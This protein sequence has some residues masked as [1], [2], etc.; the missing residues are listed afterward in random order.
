MIAVELPIDL[1]CCHITNKSKNYKIIFLNHVLGL[2]ISK[3]SFDLIMTSFMGLFAYVFFDLRN[4]LFSAYVTLSL[5]YV[6]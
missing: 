3:T 1:N 4:D 6:I 5:Y 2:K